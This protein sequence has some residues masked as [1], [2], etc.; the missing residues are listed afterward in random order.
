MP[1]KYKLWLVLAL[2]VAF[3]AGLLG[4]IFG[5]RSYFHSRRHAQL[6]Q[7]QR[8]PRHFPSLG[9]LA[10]EL[11]LS[12]EQQDQIKK[13]FEDNDAQLKELRPEMDARLGAIRSSLKDK[14]DAVLTPE[15]QTKLEARIREHIQKRKRDAERRRLR[16]D[17]ERP[18]DKPTGEMK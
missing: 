14:M 15:Q 5:E 7:S 18:Q 8:G 2:V 16:P 1:N 13:I 11:G 12:A 17:G 3:G 6:T 4:G 9:Q 10:R